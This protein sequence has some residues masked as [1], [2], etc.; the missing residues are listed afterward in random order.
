[1]DQK[2]IDKIINGLG[3]WRYDH[4]HDGVKIK[5]DPNSAPIHGDY[6][7][8]KEIMAF[9]LRQVTSGCDL[10]DLRSLDLGC[11]EGH[12]TDLLCA[13]PLKEVI[14][15]DLSVE[16][17]ARANFLL[18]DLKK[19]KN[20]ELINGDVEDDDFLDSLG[21]FDFIIFHGLLYHMKDPIRMIR[22]L[23]GLLSSNGVLLLSTQF[24]FNF[25][26]VI[27]QDTVANIKVRQSDLSKDLY[28]DKNVGSVYAHY[29]T[30][31]N[32]HLLHKLLSANGFH[33]QVSYDTLHGTR[34]SYQVHLIV[35]RNKNLFSAEDLNT[36]VEINGL[37]FYEW[38]GQSL[39]GI[40]AKKD[41]RTLISRFLMRVALSLSERIGHSYK[42]Q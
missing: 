29:A 18:K 36:E 32:L 34:Y 14:G 41:I 11:L 40:N 22:K 7:K 10:S 9:I 21:K 38:D 17:L 13:L 25:G 6:G 23:E 1:M 16:N 27:A 26:Q 12:Y 8:G 28:Q 4:Q 37:Q 42:K 31:I 2:D 30:R 20:V 24:K 5:G 39:D 19:Y 3:P 35:S 15:V 33:N